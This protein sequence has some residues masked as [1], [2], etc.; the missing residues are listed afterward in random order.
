MYS[1]KVVSIA[2]MASFPLFLHVDDA[3]I[4]SFQFYS[5]YSRF[6][7]VT[8]IF[9]K[10]RIKRRIIFSIYELIG[11]N[12]TLYLHNNRTIEF[13]FSLYVMN[14]VIFTLYVIT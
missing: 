10:S 3:K 6:M 13:H 8:V 2:G 14:Y 9:P 1:E 4:I 11:E 5:N 12:I 7:E